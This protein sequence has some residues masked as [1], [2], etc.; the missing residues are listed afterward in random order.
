[1]F[2]IKNTEVPIEVTPDQL[3]EAAMLGII[4]NFILREGTDYGSIEVSYEK[5][6]E[7]IRRQIAKSE[8][9]IVFDQSSES[10]SLLT[11]RDWKRLISA[12]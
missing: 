6:V 4:E 10:V 2:E 12:L 9:R 5:K 3:S 11:D 1:M 7:Q 8:I